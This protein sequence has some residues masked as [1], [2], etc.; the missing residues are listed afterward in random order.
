MDA[1]LHHTILT[2]EQGVSH[3][4]CAFR[5]PVKLHVEADEA[6]SLDCVPDGVLGCA[7]DGSGWHAFVRRRHRRAVLTGRV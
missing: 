7:D 2:A 1:S 6:Q 4:L 5:G 3:R